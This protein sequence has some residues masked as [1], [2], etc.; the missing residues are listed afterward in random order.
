MNDK[1]IR[2]EIHH[3]ITSL[4]GH[5]NLLSCPRIFVEITGDYE[6]ALMLSQIVYWQGVVGK[7][8]WWY[9]SQSEWSE[10]ILISRNR[11]EKVQRKL[12]TLGFVETKRSRIHTGN[13]VL[14]W[15]LKID[16]L[17]NALFLNS[18]KR[19]SEFK[20]C[21]T[22]NRLHTLDYKDNKELDI[23]NVKTEEVSKRKNNIEKEKKI[24]IGENVLLSLT[25]K[26]KLINRMGKEKTEEYINK[27]D[28]YIG[29]KGTKYKSHYHTILMWHGRD[30]EKRMV[31]LT[32]QA[33]QVLSLHEKYEIYLKEPNVVWG[34][35]RDDSAMFKEI[36][37]LGGIEEARKKGYF[38]P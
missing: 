6:S 22:Y 25:E 12:K 4:T 8:E 7:D 30:T 27:L 16:N 18:E 26:E 20:K 28:I 3:I 13:A 14:H 29:S 10:E 24:L 36:K 34:Y 1:E 2:R 17:C 15:R 37:E 5:L 19:T 31:G 23:E 21:N 33:Y 11:F 32:R 35:D 38:A 9:K